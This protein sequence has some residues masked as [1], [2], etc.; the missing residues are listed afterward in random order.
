MRSMHMTKPRLALWGRAEA[1]TDD[2][3][4]S[5]RGRNGVNELA[6][7]L[8]L[9]RHAGRAVLGACA[10]AGRACLVLTAPLRNSHSCV[11]REGCAWGIGK[12]ICLRRNRLRA[13]AKVKSSVAYG[14]VTG[15]ALR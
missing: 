7:R 8:V 3:S 4:T 14:E 5:T 1:F 11:A 6:R 12:H 2:G 10:A 15:C 9:M 13:V